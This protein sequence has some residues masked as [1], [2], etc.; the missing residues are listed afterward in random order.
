MVLFE[1][2]ILV[3]SEHLDR[4][5]MIHLFSIIPADLSAKL[6]RLTIGVL[7]LKMKSIYLLQN[8]RWMSFLLVLIAPSLSKK[9]E[10]E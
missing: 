10:S 4:V 6:D 1:S 7:P 3:D 9:C 5:G 8:P 2:L